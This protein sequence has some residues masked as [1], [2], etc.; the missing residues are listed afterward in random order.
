MINFKNTVS[1]SEEVI[2]SE[3]FEKANIFDNR[4]STM[5]LNKKT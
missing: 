5:V 2:Q 1:I 3:D 4:I